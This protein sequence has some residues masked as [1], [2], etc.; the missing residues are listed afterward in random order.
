M[1]IT[2]FIGYTGVLSPFPQV[3]LFIFHGSFVLSIVFW[4]EGLDKEW[5]K[6]CR[7]LYGILFIFY[8]A[9]NIIPWI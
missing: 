1:L 9:I 3:G 6:Y 5:S 8:L 4:V 7:I 2:L